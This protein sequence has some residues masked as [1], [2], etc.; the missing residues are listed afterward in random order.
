MVWLFLLQLRLSA[1]SV[2]L[3][4]DVQTTSMLHAARLLHTSCSVQLVTRAHDVYSKMCDVGLI[5]LNYDGYSNYAPSCLF[6]HTN[7]KPV[8]KSLLKDMAVI[9]RKG[10]AAYQLRPNRCPAPVDGKNSKS[11]FGESE[12]LCIL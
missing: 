10:R 4:A 8:E 5:R 2:E 3:R 6:V 7:S 12:K 11:P 9:L 1:V